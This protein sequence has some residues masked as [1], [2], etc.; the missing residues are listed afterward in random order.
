M[1]SFSKLIGL[2]SFH[3]SQTAGVDREATY[4]VDKRKDQVDSSE[5][6]SCR[7]GSKG[8]P[9][10]SPKSE[11]DID[12]APDQPPEVSVSTVGPICQW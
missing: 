7:S 9:K 6:R 2:F 3:C 11:M 5:G 4:F 1:R 10:P 8:A 12:E